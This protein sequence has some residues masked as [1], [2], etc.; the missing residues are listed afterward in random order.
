MTLDTLN[1]DS[2]TCYAAL[3]LCLHFLD[4]EFAPDSVCKILNIFLTRYP[5]SKLF[6]WIGTL[7]AQKLDEAIQLTNQAIIS[8]SGELGDSAYY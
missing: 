2:R 4:Y 8:C 5:N 3:A 6:L 7:V 1:K